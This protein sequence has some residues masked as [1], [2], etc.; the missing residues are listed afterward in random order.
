MTESAQGL[1]IVLVSVHGLIRG[2]DLELGRDADTGGQTKYVV[3][4]ARALARR[5]DVWR[6]DLLTRRVID[7]KV[8]ADYAEP[9]EPL[10]E[11]A[12]IIRVPAGPRRYLRKEVLW[13]YL[14]SFTDHA[15]Q[16]VRRL[17]RLPDI[18][19]SHYADAGYVGSRLASLLGVTHVH[20]GHSLGRVKRERLLA[21]EVKLETIENQYHMS[22]RIEAEEVALDTAAIVVASTEQEV[23]EQYSTYDH[24]QPK[25]M[26]VIPPGIDL[27]RFHPSGEAEE[28]TRACQDLRRFLRDPEK[29]MVLAL[30]RADER[31]NIQTLVRAFGEHE[32]LRQKANL[33]IV[34]GNRDDIQTM[35]RGPRAVLTELL[36]L[37]DR[38]DLW[39]SVAMPK[40]HEA[41]EVPCF[42]RRAAG[43]GGVFIN[44]ALTEPFGLT[45]LEAAAS[46]LPIVATKDGGPIDIVRNCRN[47]LLI[48]PLDAEAMGDALDDALSDTKRWKQ[49]AKNGLKGVR[50]YYSWESHVDTYL[51]AVQE[52]WGGHHKERQLED[53]RSRLPTIKRLLVCDLDDV[54]IGDDAALSEFCAELEQAGP[55]VGFG[56]ATGRNL[57]SACELIKKYGIPPPD[58][59]IASGGAA[60]HYGKRMVVDHA[61]QRHIMHRWEP[62]ATRAA[63]AE[64][65][66]LRLQPKAEQHPFKISYY[67]DASKAPTKRSIVRHLR[68]HDLLAHVAICYGMFLDVMPIR[69]SKGLALR[70]IAMRWGLNPEH[71]LV[72]G[73]CGNDEEMLGGNT[74]GVVVGNHAPELD[75]LR[76]RHRIYFAECEYA[77]GI[78]EGIQQYNFFGSL[79]L[80]D[81]E[82]WKSA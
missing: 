50:Q 82:G 34:A 54:L 37:I 66:G 79:R 1:Y 81:E 70:Y 58:F 78:L 72:V 35:D 28:E 63:I 12:Y 36:L 49:W 77:A 19:H 11:D 9:Q 23:E 38:Y 68:Q 67:R 59:L 69:A 64:L 53:N 26:R 73:N 57:E 74:L 17:G 22:Q 20:T 51:K 47:G 15:L 80:P 52:H 29:P 18:I 48:D 14:D 43:T 6:V 55:A 65:P 13:P 25:R 45:L 56:V 31:K 46:G 62:K 7:P 24:Y 60:I 4:V 27:E 16:H 3:E 10:G 40:H 39:G 33:V 2:Y 21:N 71:F 30:S 61:W 5:P 41:D 32:R 76:D 44:P 8:S 42:Y 75:R